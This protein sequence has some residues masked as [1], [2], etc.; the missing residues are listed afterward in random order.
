MD[1]NI[2]EPSQ[3]AIMHGSDFV[4]LAQ[5]KGGVRFRLTFSAPS[6]VPTVH[7][8]SGHGLCLNRTNGKDNRVR[9]RTSSRTIGEDGSKPNPNPNPKP[10]HNTKPNPKKRI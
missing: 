10:N 7:S 5:P 1:K 9:L 2:T 3:S 6:Q 4:S 8:Q